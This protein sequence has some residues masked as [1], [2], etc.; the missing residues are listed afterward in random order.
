MTTSILS[1]VIDDLRSHDYQGSDFS[2]FSRNSEA[3]ASEFIEN[4]EE[5]L[6][7]CCMHNDIYNI[8]QPKYIVLSLSKWLIMTL[9]EHAKNYCMYVVT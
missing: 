9:V 6:T 2:R 4:I 1:L 5:M 8:F 7:R 3:D